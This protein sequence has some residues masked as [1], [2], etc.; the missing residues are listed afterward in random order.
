[1]SFGQQSEHLAGCPESDR[2]SLHLLQVHLED[3]E[4]HVDVGNSADAAALHF[5]DVARPK[6]QQVAEPVHLVPELVR[7]LPSL[8][9]M[10]ILE[11]VGQV[12]FAVAV[13]LVQGVENGVV[14]LSAAHEVVCGAA[15]EIQARGPHAAFAQLVVEEL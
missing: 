15:D 6:R 3:V 12:G 14:D 2:H 9:E 11:Q 4:R 10:E 8:V 7:V 5:H 13:E 1:M